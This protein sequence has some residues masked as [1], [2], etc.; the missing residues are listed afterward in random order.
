MV[1]T[2]ASPQFVKNN[3]NMA[4]FLKQMIVP[5]EIQSQ[6]ID[7][8]GYQHLTADHVAKTWIRHNLNTVGQ[9]LHGVRTA[10]G[11]KPA[12]KAVKAAFAS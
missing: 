4:R 2:A 6:W 12:I 3:A 9:W 10:D 5:S 7:N 8:Y 11:S 1:Y